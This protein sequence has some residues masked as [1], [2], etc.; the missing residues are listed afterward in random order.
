MSF[1]N[2]VKSELALI[3]SH[4]CCQ[5]AECMGLSLSLKQT[6]DGKV[7]F[8][9][10]Q[11]DVAKLAVSRF[12]RFLNADCHVKVS[13]TGKNYT[14]YLDGCNDFNFDSIIDFSSLKK[15][16]CAA[17]FVRGAFMSCGHLVDPHKN[18]RLDFLLPNLKISEMFSAFL[19]SCGFSPKSSVRKDFSVNI[20]FIDSSSIEDLLTFM[21]AT[22]SSLTLMEI[23]VEKNYTNK[24][25]RK[26]NFET[27]N[28]LKTYAIS[29]AQVEAINKI[30]HSG[31]F[32]EL[33]DELR[34]VAEIRLNNPDSSLNELVEM[35]KIGRSTLDRRLKK[36]LDISNKL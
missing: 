18:Y 11:A 22:N 3:K 17:A 25:N 26:S 10:Q 28:Y 1:C 14:A 9:N 24:I 30:K 5:R 8:R 4:K 23:K 34:L 15:D 29:T 27:S 2:Q 7:V 6:A 35:S 20:Y 13:A 31:V 19:T 33:S 36:L 16:C 32:D 12:D 21:G